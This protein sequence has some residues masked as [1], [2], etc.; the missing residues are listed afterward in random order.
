M[1][2]ENEGMQYSSSEMGTG[3]KAVHQASEQVDGPLGRF[4]EDARPTDT[5]FGLV[6]HGSQE[7]ATNYWQFYT[8]TCDWVV[9]LQYNLTNAGLTLLQSKINYDAT[10]PPGR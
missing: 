6:P 5:C 3:G 1:G 7:L 4:V 10:E 2:R 8:N 9:A